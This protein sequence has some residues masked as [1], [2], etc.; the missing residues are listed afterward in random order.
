MIDWD[1]VDELRSE[2]GAE[3]F[4]EV[5]T[6]FLDEADEVAAKLSD[7]SGAKAIENALHFLKGSALNLGFRDL[8]NICQEG[9]RR[10]AGGETG[11]D[12][13]PVIACYEESK[14]AFELGLDTL[15]G[16]R[17]A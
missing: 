1:R 4:A 2:I 12:L 7:I 10:A 8:A 13:G 14:S 3:D 11:F 16:V 6:L 15:G 17:A 5:V 9:E